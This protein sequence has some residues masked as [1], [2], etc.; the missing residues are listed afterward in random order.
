[1]TRNALITTT[2]ALIRIRC[3]LHL[4]FFCMF[5]SHLVR[6]LRFH[7][8]HVDVHSGRRE[9]ARERCIFCDRLSGR[10]A[11]RRLTHRDSRELAAHR[12]IVRIVS[13]QSD[14]RKRQFELQRVFALLFCCS[15]PY[16]CK[17][18]RLDGRDDSQEED[19][20]ETEVGYK[21]VCFLSCVLPPRLTAEC[22]DLRRNLAF[23]AFHPAISRRLIE[24]SA[25]ILT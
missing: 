5:S 23:A 22:D 4:N 8:P 10:F 18:G 21:C 20:S 11:T 13:E 25:S 9:D 16:V 12:A 1:M 15:N 24:C 17:P 3:K 2:A 19:R 6:H 7:Q 14:R